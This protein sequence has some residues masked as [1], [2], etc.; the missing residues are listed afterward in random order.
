[1]LKG[2]LIFVILV[3][4]WGEVTGG[5][6]VL[7]RTGALFAHRG[8]VSMTGSTYRVLIHLQ[9]A[10][11]DV[12]I[13]AMN[14]FIR[15]AKVTVTEVRKGSAN[16]E[17]TSPLSK[18]LDAFD[19]HL[20]RAEDARAALT[21]KNNL[22][23]AFFPV[24]TSAEGTGSGSRPSRPYRQ[25]AVANFFG[26]ASYQQI[27]DLQNWA[28]A[29]DQTNENIVHAVDQQYTFINKTSNRVNEQEA[30]INQLTQLSIDYAANIKALSNETATLAVLQQ[31][32]GT[33]LTLLEGSVLLLQYTA[34]LRLLMDEELERARELIRGKV[35][36]TLLTPQE[37]RKIM[38]EARSRLPPAYSF[39]ASPTDMALSLASATITVI[40][41]GKEAPYY[42]VLEFPIHRA[43]Y[44][45]YQVQAVKVTGGE[46]ATVTGQYEIPNPFLAVLKDQYFELT[47]D[48]VQNCLT[49]LP[50]DNH[51][52]RHY[53][54]PVT[55]VM[56]HKNALRP[57]S[58]AAAVYFDSK[59][60]T[61]V[62]A[63]SATLAQGPTFSHIQENQ[64][65]Y[66]SPGTNH[67]LRVFCPPE[68]EETHSSMA[69]DFNGGLLQIPEGC[70]ARY[71]EVVL[72]ATYGVRARFQVSTP[73]HRPF[74]RMVS[75]HWKSIVAGPDKMGDTRVITKLKESLLNST[76][77]K[78]PLKQFESTL[79]GIKA[80][81][82]RTRFDQVFHAPSFAST[83]SVT[84]IALVIVGLIGGLM[85]RWVVTRRRE[86]RKGPSRA[87]SAVIPAP[88]ELIP[89]QAITGPAGSTPFPL[90]PAR[91]PLPAPPMSIQEIDDDAPE[92]IMP[93]GS[94]RS[95][96]SRHRER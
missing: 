52:S 87:G 15:N 95:R 66:G 42:G 6:D 61:D 39:S 57:A 48:L 70:S 84:T 8:T 45:L 23:R 76:Q 78:M 75:P 62:C 32:Q 53:C 25:E 49:G 79:H 64:W 17:A 33:M 2:V 44:E 86:A 34:E 28:A 27:R 67:L 4:M 46:E 55:G 38:E 47:F 35:P 26:L 54:T 92:E 69:L 43:V 14:S 60:V 93:R 65:V 10:Y 37:F 94:R 85:V 40:T 58:C 82:A 18:V 68:G 41:K 96:R 83:L 81:V 11:Y 31:A 29:A 13:E 16:T 56:T 50:S 72:P 90:S 20:K 91:R 30:R 73:V 74:P 24:P 71:G 77:L 80:D 7:H 36:L 22:L 5:G 88:A 89:L 63:Q 12:E 59:F 51:P 21:A 19:S 1:M 9:P 3:G